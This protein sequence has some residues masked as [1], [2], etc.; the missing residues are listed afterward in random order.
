M[1][2]AVATPVAVAFAA[3]DTLAQTESTNLYQ[4][5]DMGVGSGEVIS[6]AKV[7]NDFFLAVTD[8]P[9]GGVSIFKWVDANQKYQ[10]QFSINVAATVTNFN[11]VS[12]VALD[13]RGTGLGALVVQIDDPAVNTSGDLLMS[14]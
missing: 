5:I 10:Y 8:N 11:Q 14:P 13:P 6:H 1:R 4:A 3:S 12:S 7:G 2:L 9:N